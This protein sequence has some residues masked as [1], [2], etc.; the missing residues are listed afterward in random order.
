[1]P[2]TPSERVIF[3][4]QHSWM[5]EAVMHECLAASGDAQ[6]LPI[7]GAKISIRPDASSK[8]ERMGYITDTLAIL[9][10]YFSR[11]V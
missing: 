2:A 10:R 1:M 4:A 7:V 8:A 9:D 3:G 5:T 11:E 6:A